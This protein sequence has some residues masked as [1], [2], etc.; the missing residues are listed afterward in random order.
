MA[1]GPAVAPFSYLLIPASEGRDIETR[2]FD[3]ADDDEFRGSLQQYFCQES[4]T[5]GQKAAFRESLQQRTKKHGEVDASV[6]AQ[7]VDDDSGAFEI[8]PVALPR[9]SNGFV[10]TSLYIDDRGRFKDLPVNTRA[11]R[12]VQRDIRGDAFLLSNHDDPALDEWARV[13]TSMARYEELL[14]HP[15]GSLDTSNQAQMLAAG[16]MRD[17][18]TK[19]VTDEQ[20]AHA[21]EAKARGNAALGEGNPAAAQLCY[22]EAIASL[23]G[24]TDRLSNPQSAS[25]LKL[26]CFLNRALCASRLGQWNSVQGDAESALSVDG[27]SPKGWYRLVQAQ[28]QLHDYEAASSNLARCA[29]AG[30]PP[31][32]VQ[33]L[34]HDIA[35]G[36]AK[37][38]K[39]QQDQF[40][41]M[42]A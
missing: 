41:N 30:V 14:A 27:Q 24:R 33:A 23:R 15:E 32:D 28:V 37:L 22:S 7:M 18:E 19:L 38:R 39:Q 25:A 26:S 36:S 42:F 21:T 40:K 31:E 5:D 11:S 13:D 1:E 34:Q 2:R 29:A 35:V 9:Q 16:A 8:V 17:E 10:A 6:L 20:L 3:G 4:A 12:L